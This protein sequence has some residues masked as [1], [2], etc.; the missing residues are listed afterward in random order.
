M[1]YSIIV[2]KKEL[3]YL[4]RNLVGSFEALEAEKARNHQRYHHHLCQSAPSLA[5]IKIIQVLI[6]VVGTAQE[7][8]LRELLVKEPTHIDSTHNPL[9]VDKLMEL[10]QVSYALGP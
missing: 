3:K 7:D 5:A 9:L 6:L 10:Q 8:K 1:T 2:D 4:G